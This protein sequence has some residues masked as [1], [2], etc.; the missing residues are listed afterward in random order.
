MA[1]DATSSDVLNQEVQAVRPSTDANILIQVIIGFLGTAATCLAVLPFKGTNLERFYDIIFE[2][3]PVQYLELF[4]FFMVVGLIV[5]KFNIMRRQSSVIG[6]EEV[7]T[8]IDFTNDESISQLRSSIQDSDDYD[9]SIAMSRMD[10]LLALWLHAKEVDR[11][12]TYATTE[13]DRDASNS[14]SSYSLSRVLVWAIPILGFIGTVM[15]LGNAVG[16][17]SSFLAGAA[18]LS[19]IKGAIGDVT[20]GLGVA[21]DTTLLALILS[22][23][24]MFPLSAVQRREEN[25]LVEIDNYLEDSIISHLPSSEQQPIVIENL[26]DSIEAAFR[27]YI[28]DPDRYD[29]VF[30]RS[31][32]KAS[33]AV[34]E[35]FTGL[36]Q[37]YESTLHD[38]TSRLSSSMSGVGDTLEASM[39]KVIQSLKEQEDAFLASREDIGEKEAEH[40]KAMVGSMVDSSR[41]IAEDYRKQAAELQSTTQAGLKQASEASA[42]LAEKMTEVTRLAAGIQD[43]LKVQ[44]SMDKSLQTLSTSEEFQN[45][46]SD[47][48]TQ[49]TATSDFCNRM[50]KPK[51]IKLREAVAD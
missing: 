20:A 22:V 18:D 1:G 29:E 17:F 38:L 31:I 7:D 47:L 25:L 24:V 49:L 50:N 26:E 36:A 37:S 42:N 28:P 34:E 32:E 30:T 27:R 51:V 48:R 39:N 33:S 15:G 43:L 11:V 41:Q 12:S 13:A 3:G 6:M 40:F 44:E 5:L 46:L 35:K 8:N 2:R 21:F 45:T 10:R 23:L 19:A 9:Q 14:D 4:M 16:G